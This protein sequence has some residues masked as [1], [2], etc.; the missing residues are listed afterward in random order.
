M[1]VTWN[2]VL[3]YE[4]EQVT[5]LPGCLFHSDR[6]F[7]TLACSPRNHSL[8]DAEEFLQPSQPDGVSYIRETPTVLSL[9]LETDVGQA[10]DD[11]GCT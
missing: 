4:R 3:R 2:L 9:C 5:E 1:V 7:F 6:C 11:S 10:A 8:R